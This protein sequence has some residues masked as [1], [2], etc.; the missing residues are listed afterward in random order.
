[1]K[2]RIL[3]ILLLLLAYNYSISAQTLKS[4][5]FRNQSITDI[6]M[7]LAEATGTSII[8]DETVKGNASF[9]FS[10][11][12]FED[13]LSLFL[14]TYKLYYRRE[15]K[16]YRVSKIDASY[17]AQKNE[18][19]LRADNTEVESL[20]RALSKAMGKTILYDSLP[21]L[22]VSLDIEKLAPAKALEII[23]K[24]LNEYSLE[25]YDTYYYLRHIPQ[26]ETGSKKGGIAG[27]TRVGDTWSLS[28]DKGRFLE[29][30]ADLFKK[31][32]KE[33]SLL[34]KTDSALENLYFSGKSF[35]SM[36]RLLLEQGNADYIV[37]NNVYYIVELQRKDVL[38]KLKD[39]TVVPIVNIPAQDIPNLLPSELATGNGIKI[40]KNANSVI[41]S[42][43]PEEI[44]PV[45]DFI[46]MIDHPTDGLKYE[47]FDVKY[48]KVK[49]LLAIVPAKLTP[50]AP[51]IVPESNS[52]IY[53]GRDE[54]IEAMRQFL[55]VV[56]SKQ[57]GFPIK[58]K[59]L[60]TEDF[61]KILP[62]SITKE[63]IVD[64]GYPN[65]VF[66]TGSEKKRALFLRELANVD[67]PKP[68]IRYQLLVIQYDKSNSLTKKD[69]NFSASTTP[70]GS[71][72]KS[73]LSGM[74][75]NIISLNFDVISQFG[76]DFA[77]KLNI[78]MGDGLAKVFA[79]TTLN[80]LSGQDIK[81][82]NT[83]TYR[84]QELAYDEDTK[85]TTSTGVTK[86]ITSGLIITMNGWIS[87]DDMIT[88]SVNAT[89]SKRNAAGSSGGTDTNNIPS[90]TERVINTQIRTPSGKP[91]ILTGL[92]KDETSDS[93]SRVP[94]LGHIPL[95]G[96]LF[97]NNDNSKS[98]TEIVIYIIP[99]LCREESYENGTDFRLERYYG[100]FVKAKL[101]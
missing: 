89:V 13:S 86:E 94:I 88:M 15:G 51:V 3:Q 81:F 9:Y 64:S 83:E 8:P 26:G 49:D 43:T 55:R 77:T 1:L 68:Q 98:K 101:R 67:R 25:T 44:T 31:A 35:D 20:L 46:K 47:K 66:F 60:K 33:Y 42:G 84:Y 65:L 91:I 76:Y 45:L 29:L 54:G 38:K 62:P 6:L 99:Y 73:S 50:I 52:F 78:Q 56:D 87:G 12:Q 95:L 40:D 70:D 21:A 23:S 57:E 24:R 16:V 18:V 72:S 97:S 82:Q 48:L 59:Y 85:K 90:T 79:D 4:M 63:D 32:G 36:L 17:D 30:L 27:L 7:V 28:L 53:L 61:M 10:E 74:L 11:S 69:T 22:S 92:I 14:S 80:G 19:H 71:E 75:S 2:K 41:L 34:T 96:Y 93:N 100:T 5:E 58:L 39:T 37:Q